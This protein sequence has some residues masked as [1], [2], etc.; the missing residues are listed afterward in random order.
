MSIENRLRKIAVI[1]K[2][3]RYM[4][5]SKRI[6]L[7]NMSHFRDTSDHKRRRGA[8]PDLDYINPRKDRSEYVA[9]N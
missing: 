6:G 7:A 4:E 2:C 9:Q 8:K 1:E 3:E 5:Y